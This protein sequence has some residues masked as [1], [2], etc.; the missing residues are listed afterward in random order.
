M[1][2]MFFKRTKKGWGV[3]NNSIISHTESMLKTSVQLSNERANMQ[4][5][6]QS[7][8]YK[9]LWKNHKN[10]LTTFSTGT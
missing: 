6:Q 5:A 1:K 10:V 9:T 7:K 8:K 3:I 4:N 2:Q